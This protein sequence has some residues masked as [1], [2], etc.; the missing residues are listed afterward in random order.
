MANVPP[1]HGYDGDSDGDPGTPRW[2]KVFVIVALAL[3]LLL[4]A[5]VLTG[6]G[7]GRHLP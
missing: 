2:V 6:H 3:G 1:D 4:V 7:P 5:L